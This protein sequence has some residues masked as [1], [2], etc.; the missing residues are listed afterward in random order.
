MSQELLVIATALGLYTAVVVSPGPNFALV[1]RLAIS[2]ARPAALGA[3]LGFAVASFVYAVLTMTGLALMLAQIGWFASLVQIAGGCYLVYLGVMSWFS[4]QPVAAA[5]G[6]AA[7][8][9]GAL[10]GMRMGAV[11]NLANPKGIT[12]FI[13]LYAVAIPPETALWA[14][15]MIL[16]GGFA[17][18]IVWY[19]AVI[20]LLSSR[21]ARAAFERFGQWIGRAIGTVLA[22]FGLRLIAEK[23]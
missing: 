9:V 21:P 6:A 3:T 17:V 20:F 19:G 14:K 7:A 11:V 2:G 4:A 12:F 1:S 10:R 23:L 16:A 13:G 15:L 18:E 5:Q 8:P 22:A